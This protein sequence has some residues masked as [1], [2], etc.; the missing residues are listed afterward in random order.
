MK[1]RL[2]YGSALFIVSVAFLAADLHYGKSWG[3]ALLA[4][5]LIIWALLELYAMAEGRGIE[6][7]KGVGAFL[8]FLLL[9]GW[10]RSLDAR[11]VA[12]ATEIG[13]LE[14]P[15]PKV[16]PAITADIHVLTDVPMLL[17]VCLGI[18]LLTC[19]FRKTGERELIGLAF[20]AFGLV[21]VAYLGG[22]AL[23][24]RYLRSPDDWKAGGLPVAGAHAV[25]LM[26]I[27]TK[28]ADSVAYLVGSRIGKI[29]L[30]PRLSPKKSWEGLLA[31]VI[32]SALVC[33]L[34]TL[35]VPGARIIVWWQAILFGVA[36]AVLGQVG[37]LVESYVKR[38]LGT[39]DSSGL[40][41]EFGGTLDLIDGVL[42]TAPCSFALF[43]WFGL[44]PG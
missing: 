3:I 8:A 39:K 21:Y 17:A 13:P 29:R 32:G 16:P 41:P 31:G 33:L 44:H 38:S 4:F 11:L 23:E 30:A 19:L 24:L 37:D 2:I 40:L 7:L 43:C 28:T 27:A 1:R 36:M 42:L 5:L 35:I 15:I 26:M 9:F 14:V 34:Y 25:L 22:F 6:P 20:T 18:L 10:W 12:P